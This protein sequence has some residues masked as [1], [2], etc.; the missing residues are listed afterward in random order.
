MKLASCNI[1]YAVLPTKQ[2]IVI[3]CKRVC[4]NCRKKK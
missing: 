4:R 2:T 3:E 1:C